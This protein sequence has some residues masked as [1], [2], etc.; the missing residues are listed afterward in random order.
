MKCHHLGGQTWIDLKTNDHRSLYSQVVDF[1]CTSG[2]H[3][4]ARRKLP[5]TPKR[6]LLHHR[7]DTA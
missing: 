3:L 1:V 4:P 7:W 5:P 6:D 2:F